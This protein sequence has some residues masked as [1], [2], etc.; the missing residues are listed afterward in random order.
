MEISIWNT[1]SLPDVPQLHRRNTAACA[2][3]LA[4]QESAVLEEVVPLQ[5]HRILRGHPEFH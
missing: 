3:L 1:S 4:F 2:D 5:L